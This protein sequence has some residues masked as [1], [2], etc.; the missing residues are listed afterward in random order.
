MQGF[1]T[2]I[3][4]FRIKSVEPLRLTTKE[5]R[6]ERLRA[7]GYNLFALHSEDVMIDLLTD[8]GTGAMSAQQWA[9][10][11]R[12]RELRR[13]PVVLRFEAAVK[14]P[15][16][17]KHVIPTHQGRAAEKILFGDRWPGQDRAQQHALRHHARQRRVA[18]GAKA[19]DSS[20]PR[21]QPSASTPSRATWTSTRLEAWLA[22]Q[23]RERVPL[24][25]RHDHQQLGGRPARQ[26]REPARGARDLRSSHGRAALPRRLPV[27][28]ERL[29]HPRARAGRATGDRCRTSCARWPTSP[30][31]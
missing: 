13:Q 26:P 21:A 27:R 1:R 30:T 3:E 14:R 2:I 8:S 19:V 7:A 29:V 22:T 12:R 10:I 6:E 20:S 25:H 18:T 16:R 5:E 31:G 4:P 15:D 23:A 9:A 24:G 28:R 11:S 17:L